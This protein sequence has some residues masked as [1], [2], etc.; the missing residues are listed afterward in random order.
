MPETET[1]LPGGEYIIT[2]VE[3]SLT[4]S[5]RRDDTSHLRLTLEV[6]EGEHKGER[7][8]WHAA[9][10][11]P[12]I[13]AEGPG[14]AARVERARDIATYPWRVTGTPMT[15]EVDPTAL[16][17]KRVRVYVSPWS[18]HFPARSVSWLSSEQTNDP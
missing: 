3:G 5:S 4:P 11:Y 6:A 15:G 14:A 16:V 8:K 13:A 17:G 10:L 7:V 12:S 18:E 9:L 2:I 1:N